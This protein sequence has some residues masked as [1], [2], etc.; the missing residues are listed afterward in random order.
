MHM[1]NIR[2]SAFL[3][4]LLFGLAANTVLAQ[5]VHEHATVEFSPGLRKLGVFATSG[6]SKVVDLKT[7]NMGKRDLDIQV[8]FQA[9]QD[10]EREGWEL[11]AQDVVALD[12]GVHLYVWSLRKAKP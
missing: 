12:R 1:M 8:F 2:A 7:V 9:V 5:A 10:L 3:I 6:T 11:T 4:A